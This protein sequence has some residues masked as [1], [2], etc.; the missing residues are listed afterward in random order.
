[1]PNPQPGGPGLR[2]SIPRRQGGSAI[3]LGTV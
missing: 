2:I 3:P 1:M